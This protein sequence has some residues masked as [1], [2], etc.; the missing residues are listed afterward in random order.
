VFGSLAASGAGAALAVGGY[1]YAGLWPQSQV[2]GRTLIAGNDPNEIALTFDD[3]PNDAYT[4][5]ILD[6]L[7]GH[8]ARATFF[9]IGRYARERAALVRRIREAGHVVGNH[10]WTHPRLMFRSPAFAREELAA[11]SAALE[12][13]LGEKIKYF[14]P[15]YGARRP[16]VLQTARAM[17]LVPVLWNVT[18]YDWKPIPAEGVLRN[19]E[20]GIRR[21]RRRGTGSNLL[22]HDGGPAGIG[23]DRSRTLAVTARLLEAWQGNVN[24]VSVDRWGSV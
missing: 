23:E 12:D 1:F 20:N 22:L 2:F 15:P 24:F 10:T 19:L 14:R 4:E 21:N 17:G 6:L 18:G 5:R 7:A 8:G 9:V 11:T 13:M 16:A 3:G